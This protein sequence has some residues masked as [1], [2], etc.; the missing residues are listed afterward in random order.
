VSA[1]GGPV[2]LRAVVFD[3]YGTIAWRGETAASPYAQVFARHG[4]RLEEAHEAAYFARYDG[5]EH[6]E[7]SASETAYEAWVRRRLEE[8]ARSCRVP[9]EHVAPLVQALRDQDRAPVVPYPDAADTLGALRG[10]GFLLGVCSN[11]GWD[12]EV[13][14][15]QAGLAHLVDAVVTSARVGVRKPHAQIYL[16]VMDR[17]GVAPDETLFVGDSYHPDVTGPVALGMRAAHVWRP[18]PLSDPPAPPLPPAAGRVA[19]VR[20]L[21]EWAAP[22]CGR[23]PVSRPGGPPG[24]GPPRE[25]PT[26]L[27][28]RLV[29]AMAIATGAIVA[30]IY[31]A[32][33]LLHQVALS[34]SV[35]S[36]QASL[37]VTC[38]Q[39]G[40][41]VGLVLVVPL[42]DRHPRRTL[43]VGIF[44][45]N[46]AWLSLAGAAPSLWLFE[47]ANIAIGAASVAGQVMI[48]FAADLADPAR[49]G[50]VVARLMT[51]LLIGVLG[52]RT[53]SGLVAQVAGWRAIYFISAGL[54][55]VLAGVLRS[56]LPA[57]QPRPAI[58][59]RS[60]VGA[61]FALLATE[62]VLRRRAFDGACQFAAF[63][64][65]WT[66]L[67]FLLSG[68]PYHYSKAVIGLF[69]LLGIAGV[70]AANV[71]GKLAD[72][73]RTRI[74]TTVSAAVL[75]GSFGLLA[76][77]RTSVLALV[78]GVLLADAGAQGVQITNQA[79][80]YTVSEAR[81]RVTSA[82]MVCFMAGGALGSVTSG[83]VYAA[84]GWHGVCALG[85]AYG[86]ALIVG[87]LRDHARPLPAP[88]EMRARPISG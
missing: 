81:S 3:F 42:G 12:L 59:Y 14:I 25:A 24:A 60:L 9:E 45:V 10:R 29:T 27:S 84:F 15:E 5:V 52:A 30:N 39:I 53:V 76:L 35:G 2:P 66:S 50:R 18:T 58:R 40:Y 8:L 33:P 62:P 78:A 56:V 85:A 7:H 48:P 32:Q 67:A 71:A 44:V 70:L 13:S 75:T 26:V 73:Q 4:Y 21:L 34:F 57:E 74:V 31:Y 22:G 63:S 19:T 37:V 43:V 82:Y 68:A 80:I 86:L 20:D 17:L 61:S 16:A 55:L 46:A 79:I 69:G 38:A 72:L 49:R 54:M 23:G 88:T 64:A 11:W 77:G 83:A 6:L 65:L 47:I 51:G 1:A 28:N 87:A 36:T 41:A